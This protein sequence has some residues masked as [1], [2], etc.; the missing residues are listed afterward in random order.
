MAPSE[1]LPNLEKQN[2]LDKWTQKGSWVNSVLWREEWTRCR[3]KTHSRTLFN[4]PDT[5]K[6]PSCFT[7]K[8]HMLTPWHI[9]T[10]GAGSCL[11]TCTAEQHMSNYFRGVCKQNCEKSPQTLRKC[12]C[13]CIRCNITKNLVGLRITERQNRSGWKGPQ[14][15]IW[16]NLPAQVGLS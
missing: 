11:H 14:R 12:C 10:K 8:R 15:I 16:S 2:K 1:L 5:E 6:R 4:L 9:C 3:T 13:K 7:P